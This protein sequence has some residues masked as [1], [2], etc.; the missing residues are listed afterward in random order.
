MG[1]SN[2]VSEGVRITETSPALMP[3]CRRTTYGSWRNMR[4][5]IKIRYL[6]RWCHEPF[7]T[8][9]E[10]LETFRLV[11]RLHQMHY[12]NKPLHEKNPNDILLRSGVGDLVGYEIIESDVK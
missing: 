3:D 2:G 4:T 6:C 8:S 1:I 11:D 7:T 10:Y 9:S 12:C 5:T